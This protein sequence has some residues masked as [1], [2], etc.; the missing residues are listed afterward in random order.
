M[1]PR[2]HNRIRATLVTL[3]ALPTL[4]SAESLP[5]SCQQLLIAIADDW[6]DS[7]GTIQLPKLSNIWPKPRPLPE[8]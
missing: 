8:N 3:L 5:D 6:A 2:L 7:K 4:A 1:Q